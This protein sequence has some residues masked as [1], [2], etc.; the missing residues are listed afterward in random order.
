[1][2]MP[3]ARSIGKP[4]DTDTADGIYVGC[5]RKK[6]LLSA[7]ALIDE[8]RISDQVLWQGSK[9]GEKVFEV[10]DAPYSKTE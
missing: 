10:P 9:V 2:N 3:T 1:M 7:R 6:P 8:L 4:L 5:M